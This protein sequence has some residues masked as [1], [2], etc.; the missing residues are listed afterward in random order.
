MI[1]EEGLMSVTVIRN[2]YYRTPKGTLLYAEHSPVSI[3]HGKQICNCTKSVAE[4]PS[5]QP[6]EIQQDIRVEQDLGTHR[7]DLH[8]RGLDSPWFT[9]RK[10]DWHAYFISGNRGLS[11]EIMLPGYGLTDCF[12]GHVYFGN[13]V[14]TNQLMNGHSPSRIVDLSVITPDQV[15]AH[16]CNWGREAVAIF[17]ESSE[18]EKWREV[19]GKLDV[20]GIAAGAYNRDLESSVYGLRSRIETDEAFLVGVTSIR[21]WFVSVL[22]DL[23]T[24]EMFRACNEVSRRTHNK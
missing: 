9:F 13:K 7:I 12:F 19:K 24:T 16:E 6:N 14:D 2:H 5:G 10:D 18:T 15:W 1:V 23:K 22:L 20:I 3:R 8:F 4:R 21:D 17:R 11:I